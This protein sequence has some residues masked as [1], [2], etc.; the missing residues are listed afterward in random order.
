[1]NI[2][3]PNLTTILIAVLIV[4]Y[5]AIATVAVMAQIRS[6]L[7]R[8]VVNYGA[9]LFVVLCYSQPSQATFVPK[10]MAS[11]QVAAGIWWLTS[12]SARKNEIDRP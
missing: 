5:L 4:V 12:R 11:S 6:R 2:E 9:M 3:S 1:M 10:L 7:L 8:S